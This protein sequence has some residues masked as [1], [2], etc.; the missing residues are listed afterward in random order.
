MLY[1]YSI[2]EEIKKV[3]TYKLPTFSVK[4]QCL[5]KML[6][7]MEI[8]RRLLQQSFPDSP[9][10]YEHVRI[11]DQR[12]GKVQSEE[13]QKQYQPSFKFK[14][15]PKYQSKNPRTTPRQLQLVVVLIRCLRFHPHRGGKG[16]WWT[17]DTELPSA[18]DIQ[19]PPLVHEHTKDK[20][21]IKEP[22][23]VGNKAKP[24]LPYPSRLAKEKIREKDD[25][26]LQFMDIFP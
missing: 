5:F 25:I 2:S 17:N 26:L 4:N 14:S 3:S 24:N 23:F 16:N 9:T 13:D 11:K 1:P 20:K 10:R 12:Y 7:V 6:N 19:P 22:S 15:L 21:P 18:E 8:R